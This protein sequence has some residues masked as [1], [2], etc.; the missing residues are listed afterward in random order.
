MS[1]ARSPLRTWLPWAVL[2]V[3]VVT[4]LAFGSQG[5][6]GDLTAQDRVTNLARTIKCPTCSGESAAE[7]NAPSS[8][9]VR[10]DIA[11][12][13]EQGQTDDEI[14]AFYVSRYGD[15][16]LLTPASTG[17]ASLVWI[18]PVVAVVVAGAGLVVVL[19]RGTRETATATDDDRAL[20]A[21]ARD[22]LAGGRDGHG[23]GSSR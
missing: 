1:A 20:V 2:F 8:Q 9:E 12:R 22:G 3:V 15:G 16:I 10:R 18:I 6:T 5:T 23:E 13:I 7:S 19:R 4:L 21:E 11:L 17:V 14:R